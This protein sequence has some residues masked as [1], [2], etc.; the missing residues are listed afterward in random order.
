MARAPIRSARALLLAAAVIALLNASGCS[1]H[2]GWPTLTI[3]LAV[4]PVEAAHYREFARQFESEHHVHLVLIAQTYSD[5]LRALQAE[6]GAG[7]GR[8]DLVEL[9]LSMLGEARES[10]GPLDR[11]VNRQALRLFP[12]SAWQAGTFGGRLYFVPHRLMWQA[13]IFNH[14]MVPHPPAT[15]AQLLNFVRR[16]PG[17][18]A[19]KAAR[20]EGLICDLMPF[21]WDA[22]GNEL[23]PASSTDLRAL[24]FVR[25]LTPGLNPESAVFREMSILEA[26]ARGEVWIHFNWP[27]AIGYLQSKGL[28]SSVNL[29]APLPAGPYGNATPLGGGYFGI[30]RSAPHPE[31]AAAFLRY[32]LTP[33]TQEK[34]SR[35]MNWYGSA[36][37]PPGSEQARLYAGFTAMRPFARA[38]LPV[39]NYVALS[40]SWQRAFRAV[41]FE[42]QNP[43]VALAQV[44]AVLADSS[45]A[46]NGVSD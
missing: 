34:L 1:P 6:A 10:V 40:N 25:E 46:A 8:L 3:A 7:R 36:A 13:M 23:E 2:D 41:L 39:A 30:P 37:P 16:Y 38:R 26:Q 28:A 19:F 14:L 44:A 42:D 32:L 45:R 12:A 21:V 20:Y 35:V 29:S 33:E 24:E 4:F 18:F 22:G 17:K 27:F 31:L 11:A 9:D 43:R 15:W 5:I